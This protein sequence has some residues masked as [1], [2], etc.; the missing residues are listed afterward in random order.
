MPDLSD[1]LKW[2]V[3][4]VGAFGTGVGATLAVLRFLAEQK[5]VSVRLRASYQDDPD[6]GPYANMDAALFNQGRRVH[7]ERIFA[8]VGGF[9][10]STSNDEPTWVETGQSLR[11]SYSLDRLLYEADQAYAHWENG[12]KLPREEIENV[13]VEFEDGEGHTHI[14]RPDRNSRRRL[15][16][17]AERIRR[18]EA[19]QAGK[20]AHSSEAG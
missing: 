20:A 4:I 1:L 8:R 18:V 7:V 6:G 2:A 16:A 3:A 12:T 17:W 11:R 10:T 9:G 13:A 15:K 14:A 19:D 5:H